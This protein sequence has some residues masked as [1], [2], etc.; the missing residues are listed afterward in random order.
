MAKIQSMNP[1]FVS[2]VA[3]LVL[4]ESIRKFH[5]EHLYRKIDLAL[6]RKDESTFLELTSQLKMLQSA[7][8]K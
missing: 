1:A 7:N 5:E 6:E 4:D 2:L 8:S 3:E